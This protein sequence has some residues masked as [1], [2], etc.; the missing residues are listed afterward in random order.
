MEGFVGYSSGDG[1]GDLESLKNIAG[2]GVLFAWQEK[3]SGMT[4]WI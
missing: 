2:S 1:D 4:G 3:M